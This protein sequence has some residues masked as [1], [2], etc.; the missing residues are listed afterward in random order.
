MRQIVQNLRAFTRLYGYVRYFHPSDEASCIDWDR[1][2]VFGAGKVKNAADSGE[3]K[4]VLESLFLPIAPTIQIRFSGEGF[5]LDIPDAP[6]EGPGREAVAWQHVGVYTGFPRMPYRSIRLNRG[7]KLPGGAVDTGE[8]FQSMNIVEFRGKKIRLE[9]SASAEVSGSDNHGRLFMRIQEYDPRRGYGTRRKLGDQVLTSGEWSDYK[10]DVEAGENAMSLGFGFLLQGE[11]RVMA[12]NIRLSVNRGG[13][14][15]EYLDIEN[16]SFVEKDETGGPAEWII[17]NRGYSLKT[18]DPDGCKEEKYLLI[19]SKK[20]LFDGTPE[21][22]DF[23]EKELDARLRCRVPV[24]LPAGTGGAADGNEKINL[25]EL[26]AELEAIDLRGARADDE[27]VRFAGVTIAWNIFQHFYPYFDAV[28]VDWDAELTAALEEASTVRTGEDFHRTLRKLVAGL[29]DG[30]GNVIHMGSKMDSAGPPIS[31]DWVENRVVITASKHRRLQRGDVIEKIDGNP[32]EQAL[33]DAEIYISGSPQWR[34]LKAL[35]M[36]GWGERG[37]AARLSIRREDETFSVKVRRNTG[38][39]EGLITESE[40]RAIEMIDNRIYYLKLEDI[41]W[42]ELEKMINQLARVDGVIF[43]MRG[44][45]KSHEII[46]HLVDEPVRSA[47]WNVPRTLYPD[48]ERAAGYDTPGRWLLEPKEPRLKGKIVFITDARAISAA[49][50][51][52]GIVEFYRLGEIVGRPTA[53]TNGNINMFML[54]GGF[55][56]MF[57]GM[58][59]LKHDGSQHH[60][61]GIRPTIPVE[62]TVKGIAEGRDEFLEKA[63]ELIDLRD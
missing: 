27:N 13:D 19:E 61:V 1:F 40:R 56:V 33:L 62:R 9:V 6:G 12:R 38:W 16:P 44:Y 57:T 17:L 39:A 28:D 10:L 50:S 59:V 20:K 31:V 24:A 21:I 32:A 49:E 48:R 52:M 30:H 22:G 11:G 7:K 8:A 51:F 46:R 37:S 2:A 5:D 41:V 35:E 14:E 23:V 29:Q 34:R 63:L 43:D 36:F 45:P 47:R 55:N 53:G 26:E 3:L 15:W 54:P 58:K 60:H 4:E 25:A 42:P 18:D